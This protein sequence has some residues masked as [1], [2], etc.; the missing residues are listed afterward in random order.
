MFQSDIRYCRTLKA[1]TW[2]N[3][4][5]IKDRADLLKLDCLVTLVFY[6]GPEPVL[7]EV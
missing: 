5:Q 4:T 2:I 6:A 7:N 1:L 3:R